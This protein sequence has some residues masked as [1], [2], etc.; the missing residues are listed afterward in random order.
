MTDQEKSAR[1]RRTQIIMK[2]YRGQHNEWDALWALLSATHNWGID[3]IEAACEYGRLID[4]NAVAMRLDEIKGE[5][6]EA[7]A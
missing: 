2:K 3:D 4:L 7:I 5:R 1:Q 6:S